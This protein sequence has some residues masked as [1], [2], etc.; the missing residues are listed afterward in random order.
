[1]PPGACHCVRPGVH[2]LDS[3]PVVAGRRRI[4]PHTPD[5]KRQE[6][7]GGQ[8][9]LGSTMPRP[10]D[11][12]TRRITRSPCRLGEGRVPTPPR[13]QEGEPQGRIGCTRSV[14]IQIGCLGVFGRSEG[15][16]GRW[17]WGFQM[18]HKAVP[19]NDTKSRGCNCFFSSPPRKKN[20]VVGET[21]LGALSTRENSTRD[22]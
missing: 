17:T 2:R 15:R 13:R 4:I 19:E 8:L 14:F 3:T 9:V 18:A 12:H 16:I 1:M 11:R 5:E 20:C 10:T 7:L 22:P 21:T 6:G